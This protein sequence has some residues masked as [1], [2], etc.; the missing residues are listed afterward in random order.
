[1][2][3]PGERIELRG[4]AFT[5]LDSDARRVERVEITRVSAHDAAE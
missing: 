3:A 1:V 2:P 5:V 4:L